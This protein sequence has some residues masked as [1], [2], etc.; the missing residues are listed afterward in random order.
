MISILGKEPGGMDRE[1]PLDGVVPRPP[2]ARPVQPSAPWGVFL[3]AWGFLGW[4]LSMN[5]LSMCAISIA[6]AFGLAAPVSQAAAQ[7]AEPGAVDAD[8]VVSDH[9]DWTLKQRED[10]LG[11]RLHV[12]RDD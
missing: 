10:W 5:R 4:R 2:I 3:P 8:A 11:D 12:A 6:A 1:R 7:M 9:G